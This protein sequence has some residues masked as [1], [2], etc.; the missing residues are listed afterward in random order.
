ME[1][2]LLEGTSVGDPLPLSTFERIARRRKVIFRPGAEEEKT[3]VRLLEP[4]E[5]GRRTSPALCE[6]ERW[7]PKKRQ[8][9]QQG[10]PLT[11]AEGRGACDGMGETLWHVASPMEKEE[12]KVLAVDLEDFS[13]AQVPEIP[14]RCSLSERPA[15]FP[16]SK[17]LQLTWENEAKVSWS[18]NGQDSAVCRSLLPKVGCQPC[19]G[20]PE[21]LAH[22]VGWPL[23]DQRLCPPHCHDSERLQAKRQRLQNGVPII[24][25]REETRASPGEEARRPIPALEDSQ[26]N[27][28]QDASTGKELLRNFP[29]PCRSDQRELPRQSSS[30]GK[31]VP[32]DLRDQEHCTGPSS[33]ASSLTSALTLLRPS[34]VPRFRPWGLAPVFQSMRS[35]L[36]AFADIFFSPSKPSLSPAE[37]SPSPSPRPP[38]SVDEAAATPPATPPRPGVKIEVK[39]AISEPRPRKRSSCREEEKEEANRLVLRQRRHTVCSLEV[40]RE[41]DRPTLPCL[42]KEVYPFSTPPARLLPR[43]LVHAAHCDPSSCSSLAP[44]CCHEPDPAHSRNPS[45]SPDGGQRVPAVGPG[46]VAS[47]RLML[48]EDEMKGSQENTVGKVSCIKIRKT[49]AKHQASLT[50]MGLPRPA[51]LN[52][53]EFSL[54]EIY[55]NK[56]YHTPTEKR[57]FETIFEVP[58]ERNGALVFTSQR[59]L[60]RAMEFRE[61]GLPRKQR[62]PRLRKGRRAKGRRAQPPSAEL[63][64]MLQQKLA[65]LDALFEEEVC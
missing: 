37:A 7:S 36:E 28:A 43:P 24:N 5:R 33:Q 30:L 32:S 12:R 65:E 38:A 16:S 13:T 3:P 15:L 54:E 41:L 11:A 47:Q 29:P 39:I 26:L 1:C 50:P 45:L 25:G 42:R 14:Q 56:N 17:P 21:Q 35:K 2:T 55:T 9:L 63:E 18:G 64:E 8:R 51:R 27:Q 53:K 23:R 60:K 19:Q 34:L 52:K 6:D 62:K 57:S 58:L 40:S 44:S 48:S 59:K 20:P 49:P 22:T 31:S 10:P 61:V 46:A 4:P